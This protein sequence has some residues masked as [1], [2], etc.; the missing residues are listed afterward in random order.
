M[1]FFSLL[2]GEAGREDEVVRVGAGGVLLDED[3]D[4][5]LEVA[6]GGSGTQTLPGEVAAGDIKLLLSI[7]HSF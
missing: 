2:V 3:P 1:H 6:I 7:P 5:T 4:A